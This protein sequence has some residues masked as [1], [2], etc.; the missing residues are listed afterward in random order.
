MRKLTIPTILILTLGLAAACG[1][2]KKGGDTQGTKKAIT[3]E[4]AAYD[5]LGFEIQI[6]K[7]S[8]TLQKGI[9]GT[10][11]S[12]VLPDGMNEINVHLTSAKMKSMAD[13]VRLA[14]MMGGKKVLEKKTV[15]GGFMLVKA[16]RGKLLEVWLSRK[17]KTAS[18]TVKVSVPNEHKAL[19]IR[20]AESLKV[21]K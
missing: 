9:L 20:I 3:L 16:S 4:K 1:D 18:V 17:G 2:K 5:K 10:T 8:K 11:Y 12:L 19:A 15:D 13:L 14:T 21:T 7:G 6:P